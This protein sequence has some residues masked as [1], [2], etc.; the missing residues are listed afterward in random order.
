MQTRT[1]GPFTVSAIGLGG[2]P[3]SLE[4]DGA[5]PDQARA[6]ATIHAALEAGVTFIDTADIYAPSWDQMGHNERAVAAALKEY[7]DT[8]HVV[9]GTKGGI[10]RAEGEAWGRDGSADYLRS[11]VDASLRNLDV[12]VLDLYQWHR[13]DRTRD[14]AEVVGVFKD[15]QDEGKVRAVG[16]SNANVEEIDIAI[17]V[18]GDGN[19]AS[20]QNEFSPAFLSSRG[21]LEHCLARGVAFLPWSPLG[22]ISGS[23]DIGTA[24]P[25][26]HEIAQ[27]RGVSAHQVVIA[28][29]LSLGENVIPIPGASRP[30]SIADSAQAVHLDLSAEELSRIEG[31]FG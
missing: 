22:G 13:P 26:F 31:Q 16:I 23:K 20:V 14:Y 30:E 25:A 9:V 21:E 8:S 12:E 7:G 18:L 11:A 19:L 24:Y 3:L 15:L 2:M 5:V 6:N 1:L 4:R 10:T 29:E 17:E 27:Q 28:W